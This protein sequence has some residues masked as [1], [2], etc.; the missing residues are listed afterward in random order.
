[1]VSWWV[2][3]RAKGPW[4]DFSNGPRITGI[5]AAF[6]SP[7]IYSSPGHFNL[8]QMDSTSV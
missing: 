7:G 6:L 1:M 4:P 3:Y 8:G 2:Q 5:V